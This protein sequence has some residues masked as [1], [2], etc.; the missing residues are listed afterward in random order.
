MTSVRDLVSAPLVLGA[1]LLGACI[2]VPEAG[3]LEV[4]DEVAP[5]WHEALVPDEVAT[6]TTGSSPEPEVSIAAAR[7]ATSDGPRVV[8]SA[9]RKHEEDELCPFSVEAR[10]FPAVSSDGTQMVSG[11]IE[12]SGDE[13]T[14]LR[15]RWHDVETDSVVD[16]QVVFEGYG[17]TDEDWSTSG[18]H[19]W[20]REVRRAAAEVNARLAEGSWRPMAELPIAIYDPWGSDGLEAETR[21]E[22]MAR[23]PAER[24]VELTWRWG[25][26][27]V[28]VPGVRVIARVPV[29]WY[30][31]DPDR[32]CQNEPRLRQVFADE[33]TGVTAVMLDY[34]SGACLCWTTTSMRAL[35]LPSAVFAAVHDQ[36]L[37]SE[38]EH[39]D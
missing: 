18:C 19:R 31:E 29:Q 1:F 24:P 14:S 9:F 39:I 33:A 20:W 22:D 35:R 8:V 4:R 28:R 12:G 23:P 15:V 38:P 25:D 37:A 27:V 2:D 16:S 30:G 10:G 7:R 3:S 11:W 6:W 5:A 13:T 36:P 34:E 17:D 32:Y 26:V 21:A